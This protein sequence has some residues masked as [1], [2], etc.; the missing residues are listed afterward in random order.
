MV[1]GCSRSAVRAREAEIWGR[2]I[3]PVMVAWEG[4]LPGL[5]LRLPASTARSG[6]GAIHLTLTLEDGSVLR[7]EVPLDR[8]RTVDEAKVEGRSFVALLLSR[9]AGEARSRAGRERSRAAITGCGWKCG[10]GWARPS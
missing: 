6:A 4:V 1:L 7:G 9:G 8:L 2:M 5:V 3:E 10:G